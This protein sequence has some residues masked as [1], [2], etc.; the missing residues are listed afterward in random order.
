LLRL[1][2]FAG[3]EPHVPAPIKAG[4]I[5]DK[6]ALREQLER[7]SA[8]DSLKCILVSHGSAIEENPRD[9]LRDLARSLH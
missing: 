1:M 4:V 3:D 8:I 6:D 9:A 2:G 7:W 5:K